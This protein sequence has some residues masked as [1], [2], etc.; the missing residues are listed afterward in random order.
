M[1][2]YLKAI[3]SI[4]RNESKGAF[5]TSNISRGDLREIARIL[6]IDRDDY[7]DGRVFSLD[8]EYAD[9]H[10]EI[11]DKWGELAAFQFAEKYG[12]RLRPDL[13]KKF[14]SALFLESQGC[15]DMAKT[16]FEDVYADSLREVMYPEIESIISSKTFNERQR[17]NA[18]KPRNPHYAEAIR[19]A[20]L[21]WK[22][23]PGASKGAM[24]KNLHKHFSG[25]V[26]I[27]RLGEWI[28]EKGIQPPKPK[29]YTSF[30]LILS[31][32]A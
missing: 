3:D 9:T 18:K 10:N 7:E 15:K 29:V 22:R 28:K 20:I 26:S 30:T 11:K 19:I 31:E 8:D 27:D 6:T 17:N 4:I 14:T 24:C 16:L 21:T 2:H 5:D 25:R 12:T 23:Y 1:N 13:E 32:G